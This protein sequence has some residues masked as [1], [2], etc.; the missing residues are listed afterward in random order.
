MG[1]TIHYRGKL[2]RP[3]LAE[4][5]CEELEDI[6]RTMDWK[7]TLITDEPDS[8]PVPLKGIIISPHENRSHWCLRST[9]KAI[10]EM[11]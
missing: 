3:E 8:K 7:Y 10:C 6:A 2:N 4:A 1:I 9:R 11:L 5:I